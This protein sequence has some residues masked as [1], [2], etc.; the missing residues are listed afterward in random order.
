MRVD[1]FRH[2]D[3]GFK[4]SIGWRR[5]KPATERLCGCSR[6]LRQYGFSCVSCAERIDDN[7][8]ENDDCVSA[9]PVTAPNVSIMI[10]SFKL[11]R[12]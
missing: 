8:E 3:S 12:A 6:K 1:Q 5:Q 7:F 2:S 4:T 9:A 10:L 11:Y